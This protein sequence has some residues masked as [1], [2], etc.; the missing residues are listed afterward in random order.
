M[1]TGGRDGE[2]EKQRKDE[3][4]YEDLLKGSAPFHKDE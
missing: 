4:K 3:G 2:K 1:G